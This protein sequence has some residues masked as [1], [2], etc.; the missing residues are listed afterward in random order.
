[1]APADKKKSVL[2]VCLGNICRSP[3]AEAIFV[4]LLDQK[5]VRDEWHVDSAAIIDYHVGKQPEK[6]TLQTLDKHGIHGFKH[7][8]RQ[9]TTRD[10]RTF[11]YIFGMDDSNIS[12]LD[13]LYQLA[14]DATAKVEL[15]GSYDPENV[16]IIPDPYY[17]SGLRLFE[18]VYTQ[19]LR[20]CET[21]LAQ[22]SSSS[23]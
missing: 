15:L 10:F 22:H 9:V 12:D 18:V 4:H 14:G 19:C 6:R 5:G 2:F 11:D 3:M 20:S 16:R 17:E 1:M 21:F 13:D 7:T 8:V 23:E